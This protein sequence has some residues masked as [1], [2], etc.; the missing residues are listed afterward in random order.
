[1][2]AAQNKRSERTNQY[3]KAI[4]INFDISSIDMPFFRSG[5]IYIYVMKYRYLFKNC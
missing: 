4:T 1:M 3:R 5:K 2:T